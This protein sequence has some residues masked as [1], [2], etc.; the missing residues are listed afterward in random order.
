MIRKLVVF[1]ALLFWVSEADAVTYPQIV[2]G[3]PKDGVNFRVLIQ[4]SSSFDEET[5]WR[6]GLFN[7][8]ESSYGSVGDGSNT[9]IDPN[10]NSPWTR[11]GGLYTKLAKSPHFLGRLKTL[12]DGSGGLALANIC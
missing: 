4:V 6:V 7:T 12:I 9:Y 5:H 1:V 8:G 2:L 11:K 10:W 3:G